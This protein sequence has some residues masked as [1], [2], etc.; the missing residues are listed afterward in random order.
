LRDSPGECLE[1]QSVP[2]SCGEVAEEHSLRWLLCKAKDHH[3]PD[4]G[5]QSRAQFRGRLER[6]QQ[7]PHYFNLSHVDLE[8]RQADNA[9]SFH[10]HGDLRI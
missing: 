4:G 3:P 8:G 5:N 1:R 7:A 6:I 2:G 9:T 10:G